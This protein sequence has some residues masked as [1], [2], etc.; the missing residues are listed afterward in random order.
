MRIDRFDLTRYGRFTDV[1]LDLS[2]PGV[3]LVKG[4]NEAGKSTLRNAMADLL[5]GF[6]HRTP[7]AFLHEMPSLRLGALLRAADGG[8]Q[9]VVRLK[10]NKGSLRGPGDETLEQVVLEGILVGVVREDFT[11]LFAIDHEELRTGG[12]RLLDAKGEVGQALFES[13]SSAHLG[14]LHAELSERVRKLWKQGGSLPVLNVALGENGPHKAALK[15]RD[16][17]LLKPMDYQRAQTA[18]ATAEKQ[19]NQIAEQLGHARREQERLTRLQMCF[20]GMVMRGQLLEDKRQLEAEAFADGEITREYESL[21]TA[22]H[23]V[24]RELESHASAI[25][26]FERD[27]AELDPDQRLLDHAEPI[28]ELVAEASAAAKAGKTATQEADKAERLRREAAEILSSLGAEVD[29]ASVALSTV[30][31]TRVDALHAEILTAAGALAAAEKSLDKQQRNLRKED[32]KLAAIPEPA[33]TK[34]LRALLGALSSTLDER[35]QTAAKELDGANAQL[36]KTRKRYKR[37]ALPEDVTDRTFPSDEE[38]SA[39]RKKWDAADKSVA[40]AQDRVT[41]LTEEATRDREALDR[42]LSTDP[43]PSENDLAQLREEREQLWIR[44]RPRLSSDAQPELAAGLPVN[45][46]EDAVTSADQTADRIRREAQRLADRKSLESAARQTSDR[47]A[48]AQ[49]ALGDAIE[50]RSALKAEWVAL[51]SPGEIPAP[52]LEA[53][54]DLLLAVAK[55]RE[56][57]DECD[58][59]ASGL[60]ADRLLASEHASRLREAIA[61]TGVAPAETATLAEL[62]TLAK[63]QRDLLS[64]QL[65]DRDKAAAVA[66]QLRSG[67]ADSEQEVADLRDEL[68]DCTQRWETMLAEYGLSGEPAEV[69][70]TLSALDDA[71]QLRRDADEAEARAAT[72][73]TQAAQFAA[74]LDQ[75]LAGCGRAPVPDASRHQSAVK[76]LKQGLEAEMADRKEQA[77]LTKELAAARVKHEKALQ[78]DQGNVGALNALLQRASLADEQELIEAVRRGA[79]LVDLQK[80]L[81]T[82]ERTLLRTGV[83]LEKLELEL[84]DEGDPDTLAVKIADL[85]ST[86]SETQAD[87]DAAVARLTNAKADVERMDG[88]DAAA[89]AADAVEQERAAISHHAHDYL[90]LRLAEQILLRCI[91]AYRQEHQAPVLRAAQRLFTGLTL[92]EYPELVADGDEKNEIVLRARQLDGKLIGVGQMSEGTLDQLYL[93]LRL[94]SLQHYADQGRA[95]PLVLDDVL[96]TFDDRRTR[97]SFRLLN[98]IADRFQVIVLTHHD[99][100]AGLAREVLPDERIH[101]HDLLACS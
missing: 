7:Y 55:L 22:R 9:E 80:E 68:G 78:R 57:T 35:I 88:S 38:V 90:R 77:R 51:W 85:A 36:A 24:E 61:E 96:M 66:K 73:A 75:V 15:R 49:K 59:L 52:E 93:A 89:E 47:L 81:T 16:E 101:V 86:V 62:T 95:M 54:R 32:E 14:A 72:A 82:E 19:R 11:K 40:K 27:L 76:A 74:L 84:A 56:L 17:V 20:P 4:P 43:P 12:R 23:E 39:H 5:Y 63:Q 50:Q 41:E 70:A 44:L 42:F 25:A 99:H 98:E 10:R 3:H 1:S 21:R 58:E 34:T 33:D 69:S 92:G 18:V 48:E 45:E 29:P 64:K 94:A 2:G 28:N 13:R 97:E 26:Q 6:E 67:V 71:A 79:A 91:E 37:F 31:R 30:V 87:Y 8:T 53:A 65:G 46:F 83:S 60:A 100:I